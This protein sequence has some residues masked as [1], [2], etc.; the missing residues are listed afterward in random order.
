MIKNFIKNTIFF[1]IFVY[2]SQ[3]FTFSIN[4]LR[5]ISI[6]RFCDKRLPLGGKIAENGGFY[7]SSISD[8]SVEYISK[9][10]NYNRNSKIIDL[11]LNQICNSAISEIF[12]KI[13]NPIK[14]YL[15]E[16]CYLDGLYFSKVYKDKLKKSVS[17]NW[18]TDN[19]GS[20]LK[21]FVC[22]EGD[23]SLPT[24]FIPNKNL[25]PSVFDYLRIFKS[26]VFRYL[27][28]G[29]ISSYKDQIEL[30]HE[31]GSIFIFDTQ[32]LHRGGLEILSNRFI[33]VLEFS[34]VS[35]HKF[36]SNSS[37]GTNDFNGFVFKDSLLNIKTFDYFLDQSRISRN[38]EE[39][40]Y[41]KK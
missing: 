21:V 28:F 30:N 7:L 26:E 18:H 34:S 23:G 14:E 36:F 1:K 32:F 20:R 29:N 12:N 41:H 5:L 25:L 19:V 40:I 4:F 8:Q 3:L 10:E 2:S 39:L 33:L 35:K 37:L 11:S 17:G 38:G 9:I 31:T 13:H 15:G 24:Y 16:N 22:F 6:V 27:P